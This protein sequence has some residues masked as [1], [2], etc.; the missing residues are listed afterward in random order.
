MSREVQPIVSSIL[1]AAE[2]WRDADDVYTYVD[3]LRRAL[4]HYTYGLF[5]YE[6][7]EITALVERAAHRAA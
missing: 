3:G 6:V 5:D 1:A 7:A 2:R 4:E